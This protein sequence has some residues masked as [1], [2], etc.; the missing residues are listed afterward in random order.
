MIAERKKEIT[1]LAIQHYDIGHD[2]KF[3]ETMILDR[4]QMAKEKYQR[5]SFY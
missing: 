2:I 4:D 1:V 5:N 3:Q